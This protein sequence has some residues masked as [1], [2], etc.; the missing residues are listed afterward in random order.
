MA[1][2]AQANWN[3]VRIVYGNGDPTI[4][5]K[6]RERTC[7]F[8]WTQSLE[9]HTTADIRAELQAL[10]RKL[11]K[12][13]K[14]SSSLEEAEAR[15]LAIRSWWLASGAATEDGLKNLE[16]WLAFWHFRYLQ[17]GGFMELVGSLLSFSFLFFSHVRNCSLHPASILR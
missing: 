13:Y 11:C 9:K 6:N 3:V 7:L 10:H 1:D 16:L 4:R 2:S 15:Y 14:N 17:W 5:M 12:E 8:H